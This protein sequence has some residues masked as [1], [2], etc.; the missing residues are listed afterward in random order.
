MGKQVTLDRDVEEAGLP[1]VRIA[2]LLVCG[3]LVFELMPKLVWNI[4]DSVNHRLGILSDTPPKK[5]DYVRFP[6][7]HPLVLNNSEVLLTKRIACGAGDVVK[8]VG[9]EIHCNGQKMAVALAK[10]ASGKALTPYAFAG[11]IPAGQV[12][13][14]GDTEDSFDGR[15]WGLVSLNGLQRVIPLI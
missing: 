6:F 13:L 11:P 5:G 12:L 4:T 1:W 7:Q 2:F 3:A 8:T 15:Y 9:S 14:L 10:T